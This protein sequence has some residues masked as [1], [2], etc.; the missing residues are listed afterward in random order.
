M[1]D[2]GLRWRCVF[3]GGMNGFT[4][5]GVLV[6]AAHTWISWLAFTLQD[7]V[8]VEEHRFCYCVVNIHVINIYLLF[9]NRS[10]V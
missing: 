4:G 10:T 6:P 2:G 5:E 1:K 9:K 3:N 7:G 8:K